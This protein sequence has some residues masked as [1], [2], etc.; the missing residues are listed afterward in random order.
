MT[1]AE[2]AD[3]ETE[4]AGIQ[5]QHP[6]SCVWFGEFTGHWWAT[7]P[8]VNRLIEAATPANLDLMLQELAWSRSA[9]CRD[10]VARWVP[11][12]GVGR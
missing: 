11:G 3:P 9:P 2:W 1:G 8:G 5:K 4:A 6:G 10:A 7:L 12:P